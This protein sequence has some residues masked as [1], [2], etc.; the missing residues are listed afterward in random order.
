[1]K[2]VIIVGAGIA[3][4]SAGI[5]AL[6]SGFNVTILEQHTIPGGN[7][8]SWKR[9]GYLFEGG[10]HWLTGSSKK[11]PLHKLWREVGALNDDTQVFLKN[12]FYTYYH[13]GKEVCLYADPD[14]LEKHFLALSPE[15]EKE[16]KILCKDIK[17][18]AKV[19]MPVQDIKGVK[20]KHKNKLPLSMLSAMLPIMPKMAAYDK[21]SASEYCQ[22]FKHPAIR[23]L[24]MNMVGENLKATALFFTLGCFASGDGGYVKGGSL[25]LTRNMAGRFIDLGGKIQYSSRVEKV[26]TENGKA[27]GVTVNGQTLKADAVIVTADTV[28]ATKDLFDPPLN[29]PWME[30]MQK[31]VKFMA[32]IFICIGVETD[33]SNLPESMLFSINQPL[34]IAGKEINYLALNNYAK[35]KGYAPKGCSALTISFMGDTYE[36]WKEKKQNGEYEAEK[37]KIAK[38]VIE[39]LA[40]KLPQTAGKVVAVDVATPL[41]YERYC[42]TCHGSWMTL[43]E[44]GD[45]MMIYPSISEKIKSLYFAGQRLQAPGGLPVAMYTGRKAVQHLCK[46]NGVIFQGKM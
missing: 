24:L 20:V 31:N 11:S 36:Y 16:I 45:K 6:Q 29:E 28:N 37:E 25:S 5:Y 43:A 39:L 38:A 30:R 4:L 46:D 27:S 42:S 3:G 18:F 1:M 41:T 22:R 7:C 19:G 32:N 44:K 14:K 2:K 35:F 13:D 8:T 33:V 17:K 23:A 40:Q 10:L 34:N 15:D 9:K 21:I 26:L 12:S